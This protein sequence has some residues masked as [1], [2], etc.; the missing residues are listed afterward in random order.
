MNYGRFTNLTPKK[1]INTKQELYE[2]VAQ[3][4]FLPDHN[5]RA[6]SFIILKKIVVI[7]DRYFLPAQEQGM[8]MINLP[9]RK[10]TKMELYDM[11]NFF[12]FKNFNKVLPFEVAP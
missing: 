5:D 7:G 6:V 12:L 3:R 10:F 9:T 2:L 11:L 4:Y 8:E 1:S